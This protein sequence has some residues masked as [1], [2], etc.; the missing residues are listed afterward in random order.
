VRPVSVK[1][2]LKPQELANRGKLVA[3][4]KKVKEFYEKNFLDAKTSDV[5]KE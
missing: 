5:S 4:L 2:D 3:L 1:L